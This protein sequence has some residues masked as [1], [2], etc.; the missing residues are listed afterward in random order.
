MTDP[1]RRLAELL[2]DATP[3]PP[4][5]ID[6]DRLARQARSTSPRRT[7]GFGKWSAPALAAAAVVLVVAAVAVTAR[8]GDEPPV[9][10]P[11]G[12]GT[13]VSAGTAGA[14]PAGPVRPLETTATGEP[15]AAAS[16]APQTLSAPTSPASP[17][18][19]SGTGL[20][21][22]E[23]AGGALVESATLSPDQRTLVGHFYG[24][25]G[26]KSAPCGA[27]YTARVT[28]TA[29]DVLLVVIADKNP[30]SKMCVAMA[31][32]R[33]VT[34]QLKAPLADRVVLSAKN[35]PVPV[36]RR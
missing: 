20:P 18:S 7:A 17:S 16:D 23:P 4:P 24:A 13:T 34:A 28:E 25:P 22:G 6:L 30:K 19:P 27:D 11:A 12:A 26:P 35:E 33:T 32:A 31:A 3:E 2:R 9:A 29:D 36:R 10:G 15:R 8:D 1:E 21:V 5:T 14:T